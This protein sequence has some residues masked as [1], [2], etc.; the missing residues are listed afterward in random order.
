MLPIVGIYM[1]IVVKKLRA[2]PGPT[3]NYQLWSGSR[4]RSCRDPVPASGSHKLLEPVGTQVPNRSNTNG[5]WFEKPNGESWAP[6]AA[7][8]FHLFPERTWVSGLEDGG[9]TSRAG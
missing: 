8:R 1:V 3:M 2:R 4:V 9:G 7:H 5:T 6:E